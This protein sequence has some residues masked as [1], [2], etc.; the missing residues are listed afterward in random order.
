MTISAF[1]YF[2]DVLIV[3]NEHY[4]TKYNNTKLNIVSGY[5]ENQTKIINIIIDPFLV[6]KRYFTLAPIWKRYIA[7]HSPNSKFIILGF[8]NYQ[9][10]NYIDLLN[11]PKDFIAYLENALTV[12]EDWEI[13]IDGADMLEYLKRFF[14]G[15]GGNSL[16]SR[17]NAVRQTFNVADTQL[18]TGESDFEY[19]HNELLLPIG[20]PEWRELISCWENYYPYFKY[21]PFY[22]I[23]N[24]I[25]A[26]FLKITDFFTCNN[27]TK[28]LFL[29]HNFNKMLEDVNQKLVE[30]DRLYIRPEIYSN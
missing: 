17:L 29:R 18:V 25:N 5:T 6:N 23:I 28:I 2:R 20:K 9:S 8:K 16:L 19:I 22:P 15:H 7:V 30:I 14:K 1:S 13:P 27:P 12:K 11:L 3:L 24:K 4:F 26:N 10:H 21:L